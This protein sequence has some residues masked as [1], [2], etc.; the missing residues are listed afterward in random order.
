[1][2]VANSKSKICIS[3]GDHGLLDLVPAFEPCTHNLKVEV[4]FQDSVTTK[5]V[6]HN[7]ALTTTADFETAITRGIQSPVMNSSMSGAVAAPLGNV[8]S[9]IASDINLKVL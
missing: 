4:R 8:V 3:D 7:S 2:H 6:P 5:S 1:M 9:P